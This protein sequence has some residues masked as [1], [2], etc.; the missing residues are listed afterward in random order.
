MLTITQQLII[1]NWV[2]FILAM[3]ANSFLLWLV[4][5]RTPAELR[6]YSRILTQSAILN[7]ATILTEQLMQPMIVSRGPYTM[8][9]GL[10]WAVLD[11]QGGEFNRQWNIVL[12]GATLFAWYSTFYTMSLAYYYRYVIICR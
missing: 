10:G 3:V 5:K 6:I 12:L 1:N 11:P 2:C 7:L 9:C 4:W 8:T